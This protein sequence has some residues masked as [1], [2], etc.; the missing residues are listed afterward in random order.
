MDM[1]NNM[2]DTMMQHETGFIPIITHYG[3]EIQSNAP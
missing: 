1:M 3:E 2:I